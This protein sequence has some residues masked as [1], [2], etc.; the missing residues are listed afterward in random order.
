MKTKLIQMTNNNI[1]SIVEDAL[2]PFGLVTRRFGVGGNCPTYTIS[3]S[4]VDTITIN[5]EGYYDITYSAS[6]I[7]NTAG[8]LGLSL[9]VNGTEAYVVNETVE[10]GSTY[11]LTL[12][13]TV[14]VYSKCSNAP[15]NN[16][17]NIQIKLTGVD[18]TSAT[19]NIQ[20]E[21]RV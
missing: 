13:Y 3:N 11:N 20:I 4:N 10:V 5:D 7:A 21:K 2:M 19:S 9:Q 17:I 12:P 16:P 8:V 6:V 1:G 18:I 14:R 15:T